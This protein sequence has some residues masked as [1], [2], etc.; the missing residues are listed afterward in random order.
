L[1]A[2]PQ[3]YRVSFLT[4]GNPEMDATL[5]ATSELQ[6][7]RTS[8]PVSPFGLIARAR[9]DIDRLKTVL[10]S[11]G[12]Y[13]SSVTI[14]IDGA[15][16]DS[17]GLSQ[18][19]GALPKGT[20]AR[21]A[22]QFELGPLYHLRRVELD[23]DLPE[24]ARAAFDLKSGDPA[25]AARVLGAGAHLLGELQDEGFAF[26][27]VDAPVAYQDAEEPVLDVSFHATAG[28]RVNIGAI[29]VTG[30]KRLHE[31]FV[32]ARLLLHSGERY[33]PATIERARHDLLSTGVFAT[34][35]VQLGT[36]V[37][38]SGGVPVTFDVRERPLH[39]VN[40]SSAYS[41]DLG[42][43]ATASWTDRDLFGNA[44]K[45]T[46]AASVINLGGGS[47]TT[48]TG[49]DTSVKLELPDIGH[50]D[51]SLQ[52]SLGALKQSLL[53]YDQT[54][55][56]AGVT[57]SRKLT[58]VWTAAAGLTDAHE[59]I[60][61]IGNV[62]DYTLIA[63]PLS[64]SYDST[65]LASP[66]DDPRH[67]MRDSVSVAPTHSFGNP[68]ATFIVSQLKIAEYLDLHPLLATD[69]GRSVLALRGLAG[70]VEGAGEFSLPPD[71]RFYAGGSG[72]IRGYAY[73]EVGPLYDYRGTTIPIGG[74][75]ILAGGVEFRQRVGANWGL[76]VFTDAGEV[77]ETFKTSAA[78]AQACLA[79]VGSPAEKSLCLQRSEFR[80]G[81][82]AGIRYYTPIGPVR[83]DIAVP[84]AHYIPDQEG[85]QVYVGLGQA[86]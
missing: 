81:V 26:A 12:F 54:A 64:L 16:L 53:A 75:A 37:D 44:E 1:A 8:A 34:V 46:F 41:T 22:L 60:R 38:A 49:Y 17:E 79:A 35:T 76:A 20:D 86:F 51:Q 55:T 73:Q 25:V 21:V 84:T 40:L 70:V 13:D 9:G 5:K 33:N 43:S 7:L 23:G 71:Q 6:T 10:E 69:P 59:E 80:I 47:A 85:F 18:T 36:A 72:T 45:L 48:G 28:E 66:L 14:K 78:A 74:N 63:L 24:A 3:G 57:L 68:G 52:F 67:G 61:Q 56:T 77:S 29:H 50:R 27:K 82:G 15:A 32:R 62:Y 30:L 65:A 39:A 2:D 42:G 4:T 58:T 19:L 83:V 11:Y 31:R